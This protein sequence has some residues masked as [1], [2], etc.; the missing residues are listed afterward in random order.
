MYHRYAGL[1]AAIFNNN[2]N[3]IIN[4]INTK[5]R[6]APARCENVEKKNENKKKRIKRP[7]IGNQFKRG[8]SSSAMQ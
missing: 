5:Y 7:V 4:N 6:P 1:T 2:N 8:L 3:N